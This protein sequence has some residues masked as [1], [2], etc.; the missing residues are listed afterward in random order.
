[1][2]ILEVD[3]RE[4]PSGIPEL[5]KAKGARVRLTTLKAGDYSIGRGCGIERKRGDD[6][7]RSLLDGRLFEQAGALRRSYSRPILILEGLWDGHS[8]L[9]VPWPQLRGALVSLSAAFGI[10]VISSSG[11]PE[12]AEIILTAAR[13]TLRPFTLG[14]ARPGYRPTGWRKRALFI[15]QGLPGVGPSRAAALLGAF[16]S[17]QGAFSADEAALKNVTGIG[18]HVARKIRVAVSPSPLMTGPQS[19]DS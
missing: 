9:G 2:V 7:A 17:I 18:T 8:A 4:E 3:R 15:L 14:Y 16:G 1:M 12:T 11:L 13:Q 19:N 10:P 6:F 5:L